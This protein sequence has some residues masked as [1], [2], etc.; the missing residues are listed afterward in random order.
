[1]NDANV[2][3]LIKVINEK[4]RYN[5]DGS[6]KKY[7]LTFSQNRVLFYLSTHGNQASQKEIEEYLEVSHPTAAGL[8]SRM[9]KA[10]IVCS[11]RD[12]KDR[13]N[14]IVRVS[15]KGIQIRSRI[16]RDI[17]NSEDTLIKD[18]SEKDQETLLRL[19]KCIYRNLEKKETEE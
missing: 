4:M 8:V 11:S 16:H 14:K 15:D 17:L 7:G 6:L 2:G 12:E 3:H 1:M 5:A 19:L 9:E 18:M 10:G 13:R